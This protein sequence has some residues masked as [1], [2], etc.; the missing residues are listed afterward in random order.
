MRPASG[1]LY[2]NERGETVATITDEEWGERSPENF[3]TTLLRGVDTVDVT[4]TRV[5]S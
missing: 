1:R 5:A 3:D 2:A 4:G